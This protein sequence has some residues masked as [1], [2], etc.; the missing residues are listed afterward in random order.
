M[1]TDK[2][3]G[4]NTGR[5]GNRVLRRRFIKG[6]GAATVAGLAGCSGNG[7]ESTP[8]EGASGGDDSGG[9]ATTTAS[10]SGG[11]LDIEGTEI[12][13]WDPDIHT[14]NSEALK[15]SEAFQE[16]VESE[17]GITVDWQRGSPPDLFGGKYRT[18]LNQGSQPDIYWGIFAPFSG[19]LLA[20][21]A[22]EPFENWRGYLSD[23]ALSGIEWAMP[24]LE[25]MFDKWGG[26]MSVP[27]LWIVQD[28]WL[29]R[30]DHFEEA[31]LNPDEE[32]PFEG[33][34]HMI[35]VAQTLQSDGPAD[36]AL[37][38]YSNNDFFDEML[39]HWAVAEGGKEGLI[40]TDDWLDVR[41]D[42]STWKSM[43]QR[44]VDVQ[45]EYDLSWPNAYNSG[46]E[47]VINLLMSGK[48]SMMQPNFLTYPTLQARVP[49]L[50]KEGKLRYAR[51]WAGKSGKNG[52]FL[53]YNHVVNR[54]DNLPDEE[55]ERKLKASAKVVDLWLQPETQQ[56]I[57]QNYGQF[58]ANEA[59]W[60]AVRKEMSDNWN[61]NAPAA[62]LDVV[63]D[64]LSWKVHPQAPTYQ[65]QIPVAPATNALKGE[66]SPEEA[67]DEAAQ[68]CREQVNFELP[69]FNPDSR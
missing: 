29:V 16:K 2:D 23:E 47:D 31:G 35:S 1:A 41:Y 34:E 25:S 57:P 3:G 10:S 59:A 27:G 64:T 39:P 20:L 14:Q 61:H 13:I 9:G 8:T 68:L 52:I 11:N 58:P 7:D 60:D 12:V 15:A 26:V 63:K 46:D 53:P 30:A 55:A 33:Y 67:M 65:Y 17:L 51:P 5:S 50:L 44:Y 42:N 21:D 48:G 49:D 40:L 6:A 24:Q 45:Q 22:V 54:R 43:L 32:L 37:P 66:I 56:T 28:P 4:P 19:Q 36:Y 18:R 69:E 38:M 62:Q